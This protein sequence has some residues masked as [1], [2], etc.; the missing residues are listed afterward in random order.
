MGMMLS[1]IGLTALGILAYLI[2]TLMRGDKQ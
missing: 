2:I 1:I